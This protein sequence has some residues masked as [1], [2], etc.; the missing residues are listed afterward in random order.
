MQGS[1]AKTGKYLQEVIT[2]VMGLLKTLGQ[3]GF[4]LVLCST[5][6]PEFLVRVAQLLIF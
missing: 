2:T 5:E 1:F 4:P 3:A 6:C